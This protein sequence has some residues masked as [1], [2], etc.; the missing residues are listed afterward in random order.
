[1]MLVGRMDAAVEQF[2]GWQELMPE[3]MPKLQN[4]VGSS[5]GVDF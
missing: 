3:Y 5:V 2:R 4:M 1:M